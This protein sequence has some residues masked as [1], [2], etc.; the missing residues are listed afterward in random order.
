[1]I[2][3]AR[4][5]RDVHEL[6]KLHTSQKGP[7]DMKLPIDRWRRDAHLFIRDVAGLLGFRRYRRPIVYRIPP[8]AR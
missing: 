8:S 3:T 5:P 7:G 4:L 1:M 6:P 2:V